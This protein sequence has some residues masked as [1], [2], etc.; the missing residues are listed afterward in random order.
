MS[1][2]EKLVIRNDV[3]PKETLEF[4]FRNLEI[5]ARI[6]YEENPERNRKFAATAISDPGTFIHARNEGSIIK[7]RFYKE[8]FG[9][10]AS[11]SFVLDPYKEKTREATQDWLIGVALMLAKK[12]D[13]DLGIAFDNGSKVVLKY[14]SN[15]TEMVLNELYGIWTPERLEM[16]DI[17]YRMEAM[18]IL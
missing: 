7:S 6:D 12:K 14:I 1:E 10:V 13:W 15:E 16:V 4:V 11:A 2:F 17:P 8:Q 3:G 18:P 9:F 5:D